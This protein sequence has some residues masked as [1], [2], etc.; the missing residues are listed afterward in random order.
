MKISF[1]RAVIAVG[2]AAVMLT[3][4]FAG[5]VVAAT[6]NEITL[7]SSASSVKQGQAFDMSVDFKSGDSGASGFQLYL[8]YDDSL[9]DVYVPDSAEQNGKYDVSSRFSV[10]TN[11]SYSSSAVK[12]V[13][14]NLSANNI[15]VDTALSLVTFVPKQGASGR[16]AFWIE[17]EKLVENKDGS[18]VST[19]YSAPSKSSP[20][21]VS[22]EAN[23]PVETTA[24]TET[25]ETAETSK[26]TASEP[27]V[28]SATAS[29]TTAS[30]ATDAAVTAPAVST[31]ETQA[32]TTSEPVT[33]TVKAVTTTQPAETT[34][35]APVM[36]TEPVVTTEPASA[37][38]EL[39]TTQ[40]SASV[41]ESETAAPV[42]APQTTAPVS[43]T[44]EE[45]PHLTTA[46]GQTT[47]I[48]P[49]EN[50]AQSAE[51]TAPAVV[52]A[53]TVVIE[54]EE[55][56]YEY[57]Q[58][59]D[60]YNEELVEPFSFDMR[61]YV[62]DF[63]KSYN[64]KVLVSSDGYA[65]GSISMNDVDG[66]WTK[67][68]QNTNQQT[69]EADNITLDKHDA[70][71]FVQ[72]F[73]IEENSTFS[74]DRI[75]ITPYKAEA[76]VSSEAAVSEGGADG[77]GNVQPADGG[78]DSDQSQ[79]VE[80]FVEK[81]PDNDKNPETSDTA[82]SAAAVALVGLEIVAM[83]ATLFLSGRKKEENE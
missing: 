29:V 4:V 72:L 15:T 22:I 37:T 8:H 59:E 1:K 46:A 71:V 34:T 32:T 24:T 38:E 78:E 73:Y 6:T 35:A 28:A 7:S 23:E 74:V 3:S 44:A 16:A 56:L 42:T 65:S 79:Q 47:E 26:T 43:T 50:T 54:K 58:G 45:N 80:E 2:T 36:T 9:L 60:E 41:T 5:T 61:E 39:T 40:L 64:I 83:S 77:D 14:A 57:S 53:D 33:T 12:I 51:Q 49:E 76:D 52:D 11:Y 19:S 69:W 63:D 20:V 66:N 70:L 48:I 75:E 10:I 67:Y 18:M 27:P 31:T 21:Y 17:V 62:E 82:K 30:A 55:P 81:L 68:Y 25:A 13:G